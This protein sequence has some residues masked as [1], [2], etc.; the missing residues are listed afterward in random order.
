M[1]TYSL[2]T[3]FTG[4]KRIDLD[5]ISSTNSY[6]SDL[7]KTDRLPE[8]TILTARFQESGKGQYGNPWESSKGENLLLSFLWYPQ[9]VELHQLHYLNMAF[10][11]AV[12]DLVIDVLEQQVSI[13][14]PND[15]FVGDKKLGGMLIE[16]VFGEDKIKQSILGIGMNVNQVQ[17]SDALPNPISLKSI[18]GNHYD[19]ESLKNGLCNFLEQRYLQLRKGDFLA[20][21]E[22]Y[23]QR[24]YR[25]GKW[26]WFEASGRK[27]KGMI[28]GVNR[29]GQ[30]MIQEESGHST[31]HDMKQIRYLFNG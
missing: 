9:F 31:V 18:T 19:L 20:I 6:L 25:H 10:A 28:M 23:H 1:L 5:T 8:G 14:W 15:I 30:L 21:R 11:V 27:F 24:L 2:N 17:F 22:I 4:Q 12:S 3:L 13:K 7:Q 16:N 29:D 26:E